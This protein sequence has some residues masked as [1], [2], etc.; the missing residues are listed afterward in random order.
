[1]LR[2]AFSKWTEKIHLDKVVLSWYEFCSLVKASRGVKVLMIQ[3]CTILTDY[4]WDFGN[5]HDCKIEI[6][7]LR[8]CG[9]KSY[10]NWNVNKNRLDNILNGIDRCDN[11]KNT[12]KKVILYYYDPNKTT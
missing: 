9:N 8:E 3:N 6:L 5:M 7:D 4:E 2:E 12:L 1:M 11:L 10:S